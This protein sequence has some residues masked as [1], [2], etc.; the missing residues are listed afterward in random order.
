MAIKS[1]EARRL[2]KLQWSVAGT[3]LATGFGLLL[4]TAGMIADSDGKG[5]EHRGLREANHIVPWVFVAVAVVWFVT[6]LPV[7][8]SP[9]RITTLRRCRVLL[10]VTVGAWLVW[11]VV[12]ASPARR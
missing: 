7:L 4:A 2:S 6:L 12:R 1:P 8:P 11:T 3:W 9:L 5:P 10:W